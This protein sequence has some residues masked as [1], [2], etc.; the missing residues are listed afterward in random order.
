MDARHAANFVIWKGS[1]WEMAIL[2]CWQ[3]VLLFVL[4][5]TGLGGKKRGKLYRYKEIFFGAKILAMIRHIYFQLCGAHFYIQRSTSS[6][7]PKRN[8]LTTFY[9]ILQHFTTFYNIHT[10]FTTFYNI[11]T[12]FTTFYN[13]LQHFTTLPMEMCDVPRR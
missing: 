12:T 9:N 2:F 10:T 8:N 1:T 13:I 11:H 6:V 7:P 5:D 4:E 3:F